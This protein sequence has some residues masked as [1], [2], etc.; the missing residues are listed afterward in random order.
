MSN[1]FFEY[2]RNELA[3]NQEERPLTG[4]YAERAV[5]VIFAALLVAAGFP[6]QTRF[7]LTD[8][9]LRD[10]LIAGFFIGLGVLIRRARQK[11]RAAK[12]EYSLPEEEEFYPESRY[13]NR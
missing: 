9:P 13:M 3:G 5:C 12:E 8:H 1:C 4:L 6:G 2:V 10:G 11:A 7:P